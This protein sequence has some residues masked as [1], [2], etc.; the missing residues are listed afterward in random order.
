MKYLLIFSLFVSSV[1]VASPGRGGH[2]HRHRDYHSPRKTVIVKEHRNSGPDWLGPALILGTAA[3][4]ISQ[5]Q[6]PPGREVIVVREP[7]PIRE[8]TLWEKIEGNKYYSL[9]TAKKSWKEACSDWKQ[10]LRERYYYADVSCGVM[11]CV[12][13]GKNYCYSSANAT[14]SLR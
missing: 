11:T 14:V 6:R 12:R 1:A 2:N 7:A 8:K 13:S 9:D 4:I 10:E 5:N 3:V